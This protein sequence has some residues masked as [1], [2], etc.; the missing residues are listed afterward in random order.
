KDPL[1]V[2]TALAETRYPL[3]GEADLTVDVGQGSHGQAVDAT[4]SSVTMT[5]RPFARGAIRSPA[6]ASRPRPTTT[7]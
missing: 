2:L 6:W 7:S 1:A 4:V 3:Y 5:V